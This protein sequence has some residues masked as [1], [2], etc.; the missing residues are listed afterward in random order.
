MEEEAP[1]PPQSADGGKDSAG[2]R[3][4]EHVEPAEARPQFPQTQK[5]N[6]DQGTGEDHRPAMDAQG[7]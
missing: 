3:K 6:K 4:N 1:L 2:A 7:L 5:Q